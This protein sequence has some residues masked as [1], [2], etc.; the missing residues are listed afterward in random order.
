M[1][2]PSENTCAGCCS[3]ISIDGEALKIFKWKVIKGVQQRREQSYVLYISI[4]PW[5][6]VNLTH[7]IKLILQIHDIG[8]CLRELVEESI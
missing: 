3:F 8:T 6:N 4:A 5:L 7:K 2:V 1:T